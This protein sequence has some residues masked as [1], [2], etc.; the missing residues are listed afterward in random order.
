M[1]KSVAR[2]FHKI[3]SFLLYLKK[4]FFSFIVPTTFGSQL[5]ERS[6]NQAHHYKK[7][8]IVF[9]FKKKHYTTF[10][11]INYTSINVIKF[12]QNYI[13][14]LL[15]TS[16]LPASSRES[17]ILATLYLA[18]KALG[19]RGA[20]RGEGRLTRGRDCEVR[21]GATKRTKTFSLSGPQLL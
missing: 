6:Y 5:E 7:T 4:I 11:L 17:R 14:F 3:F 12:N 10:I 20:G 16:I 21:P 15:N 9:F 1:F 13:T 8:S 19:L 2:L 18:W